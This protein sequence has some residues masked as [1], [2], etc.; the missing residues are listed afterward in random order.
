MPLLQNKT[1]QDLVSGAAAGL[2][3]DLALFPL[4]TLKVRLQ[5]SNTLQIT[6]NSL[7]RGVSSVMLGSA[8]GGTLLLIVAA[9]F[10]TTYQ[11]GLT[12]LTLKNYPPTTCLLLAASIAEICACVARVNFQITLGANG[13]HQ[14]TDASWKI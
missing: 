9:I 12:Q 7:F 5:A 1:H 8:P 13:R 14:A 6:K 2:A 11:Y 3:V 4:D 10:F